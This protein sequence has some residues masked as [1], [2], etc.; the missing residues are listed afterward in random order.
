MA[1]TAPAGAAIPQIVKF[2]R[3]HESLGNTLGKGV[4]D[5]VLFV[6][7]MFILSG[8]SEFA[9]PIHCDPTLVKALPERA[10]LPV[11]AGKPC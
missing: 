5:V 6:R 10:I 9:G 1:A 3:V 2:A 11:C 8:L 7:S 4:P